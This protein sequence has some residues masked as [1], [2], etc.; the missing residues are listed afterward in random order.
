M[1]R[2]KSFHI[3]SSIEVLGLLDA[4]CPARFTSA[5][6]TFGTLARSQRTRVNDPLLKAGYIV[7]KNGCVDGFSDA[8]VM[9]F[10]EPDQN[11]DVWVKM[12]RPYSYVNCVGTTGPTLLTGQEIYEIMYDSLMIEIID[13][14]MHIVPTDMTR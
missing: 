5:S 1:L 13:G 8:V 9:G 4:I 14:T 7:R 6:A 3:A 12:G 10:C 2:K 11:G